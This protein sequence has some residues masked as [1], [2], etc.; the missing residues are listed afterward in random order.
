MRVQQ[1]FLNKGFTLIE[2]LIT[3]AISG[4]IMTG[5]YTAFKSQQD[6]YLAQEQV[7][8]MQQNIRTGLDIMTREIRMAGFDPDNRNQA[9]ILTANSNTLL[10]SLVADNDGIDNDNA[11]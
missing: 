7:A 1:K 9:D 2:V 11:D 5:V 8:E 6:S 10:F 3:L 4:I